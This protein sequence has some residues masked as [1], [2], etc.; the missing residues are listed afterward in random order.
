MNIPECDHE[1]NDE[2]LWT[3]PPGPMEGEWLV[4]ACKHCDTFSL[5]PADK[6]VTNGLENV[7][8]M[9]G[10]KRTISSRAAKRLGLSS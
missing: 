4:K 8:A 2:R 1:W 10:A 7:I 3:A 5:R 6:D 9:F